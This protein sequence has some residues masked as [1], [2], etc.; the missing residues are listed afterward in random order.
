M[1]VLNV[2]SLLGGIGLF[3]YGMSIMGTGL[4]KVAGGKMQ[5]ILQK[6]ISTTLRGVLLGALITAVIQSSAGTIVI[7]VGLVNSGIIALPQ[8]VGVI[9]GA[10]IGTTIT[11][12]II[13]MADI[14]GDSLFL[15][16]LKPTTFS[17]IVAFIGAILFVF[18]KKPGT[19]NIGQIMMGFG[20]L[21]TGMSAMD[22]AVAPLKD[23]AFFMELFTNMQNPILGCLVGMMATI[24]IQSSSASV[25]LLQALTSTGL[26]TWGSSFPIIMGTHIGTAFTPL[27]ASSGASKDAKRAAFIHLYFN[28][29]GSLVMLAVVCTAQYTV[30][31][32]F[33]NDVMNKG[34]VANVH[35]F[36]SVLACIFLMP[37][38]K[39]L[40]NLAVVTV[41]DDNSAVQEDMDLPVLDERL[42][43]S[44]AVAI[45]Q[46][47]SAT[48]KMAQRAAR[49]FKLCSQ[50]LQGYSTEHVEEINRR[51]DLIDKMEV[52][53]SN[54]LV[55]VNEQSLNEREVA[56]TNMLLSFITEFERI[57]DYAI[58]LMETS[59][60]LWE[61]DMSFSEQARQELSVLVA[62]VTEAINLTVMAFRDNDMGATV[63]VEPLE[64]VVDKL[65]AVLRAEHIQRLKEGLCEI[66][67][68]IQFLDVLTNL[69]RISDHCSNVAARI[70]AS[71]HGYDDLDMH[72]LKKQLHA[73]TQE[74]FNRHR[75]EYENLYF[76]LLPAEDG[77]LAKSIKD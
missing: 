1:S 68:G 56:E 13:R 69:E 12:Q 74:E 3:L 16:M 31:L 10:N 4:E 70:L 66:Q 30:G 47:R 48:I 61:R 39:V 64:E 60:G 14:S 41:K 21:F 6:L 58:N 44:P 42:F 54:Y 52:T 57:G 46:A 5:S 40:L 29:I 53:I 59:Q 7:V 19:K 63:H 62:A 15:T 50:L 65:C 51:E 36:S 2:I 75:S 34:S 33:W 11:G 55:K 35:T 38:A 22:G 43:R 17:P 49:N 8:A 32:P 23:S 27:V 77:A 67:A 24:A 72:S 76:N 28:L 37:F 20:I 26:V 9:M 45:Q 25:G 71:E 73:G 18:F